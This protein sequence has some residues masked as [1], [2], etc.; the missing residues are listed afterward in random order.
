MFLKSSFFFSLPLVFFTLVGCSNNKT[1]DCDSTKYNCEPLASEV[2]SVSEATLAAM[3]AASDAVSNEEEIVQTEVE[4]IVTAPVSNTN[5]TLN[6]K[7]EAALP[8]VFSTEVDPDF[9]WT[10]QDV[11]LVEDGLYTGVDTIRV[12]AYYHHKQPPLICDVDVLWE[13]KKF[14]ISLTNRNDCV[15]NYPNAN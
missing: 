14:D 12:T 3:Q 4:E 5:W 6:P 2:V 1:S 11:K 13:G 7:V 10:I 8:L 15:S 9:D